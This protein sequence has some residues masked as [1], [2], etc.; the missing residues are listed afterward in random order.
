VKEVRDKLP[1]GLGLIGFVLLASAKRLIF[2]YLCFQRGYVRFGFL[3]IGFVSHKRVNLVEN[4]TAA[5]D[6][7]DY[8]DWF[9]G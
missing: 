3:E 5:T 9:I 2:I 8:T 6:Y 7:T 1:L 4:L